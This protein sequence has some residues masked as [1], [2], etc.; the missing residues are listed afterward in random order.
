MEEH[1]VLA[2]KYVQ[3]NQITVNNKADEVKQ[4]QEEE[5]TTQFQEVYYAEDVICGFNHKSFRRGNLH[6]LYNCLRI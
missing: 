4:N 1:P 2:S 3:N 6:K 5:N